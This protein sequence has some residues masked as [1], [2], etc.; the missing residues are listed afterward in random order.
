MQFL[1]FVFITMILMYVFPPLYQWLPD[2][3]YGN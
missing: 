3:L 1:V 2:V